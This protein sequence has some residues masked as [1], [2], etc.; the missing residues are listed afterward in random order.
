MQQDEEDHARGQDRNEQTEKL[1][2]DVLVTLPF[3]GERRIVEEQRAADHFA[4]RL[5]QRRQRISYFGK[6]FGVLT[7]DAVQ[8]RFE[9]LDLADD[10]GCRL[11]QPVDQAEL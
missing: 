10:R 11:D 2:I 4:Q 3:G 7:P 6:F 8:S 9:F 1:I 5:V